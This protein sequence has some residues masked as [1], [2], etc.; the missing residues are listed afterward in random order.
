MTSAHN[1]WEYTPKYPAAENLTYL[2][3]LCCNSII[4]VGKFDGPK[5]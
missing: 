1:G 4:F 3:F 2:S 5:S